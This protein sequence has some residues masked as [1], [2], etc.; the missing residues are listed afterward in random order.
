[1]TSHFDQRLTTEQLLAV[2]AQARKSSE[3]DYLMILIAASHGL[4]ATETCFLTTAYFDLASAE[5]TVKRGKKSNKTIQPLVSHENELLDERTAV[6]KYLHGRKH[7]RLFDIERRMFGL[8][9]KKYA[10]E[11]GIPTKL[12]HVHVLKHTTAHAALDGGASLPDI[13]A[14]LGHASLGSTGLY[15]RKGDEE[16][17]RNVQSKLWKKTD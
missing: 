5:I 12:R 10:R 3:R 13:Q 16:A 6:L 9:F 17:S 7:G 1:M 2:L 15:L 14:Y 4:R 8:L 11:V